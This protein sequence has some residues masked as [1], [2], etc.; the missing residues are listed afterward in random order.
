MRITV[1]LPDELL[2]RIKVHAVLTDRKLN[3]VVPQLLELGLGVDERGARR[4][5][6]RRK[7]VREDGSRA[8]A[9]ARLKPTSTDSSRRSPPCASAIDPGAVNRAHGS[10]GRNPSLG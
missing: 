9:T 2:R 4:A 7:T 1:E 8:P 6:L 3:E 5:P 10:D